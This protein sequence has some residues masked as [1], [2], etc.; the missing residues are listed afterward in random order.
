MIQNK[1]VTNNRKIIE[2]FET[3][4]SKEEIDRLL[5]KHFGIRGK[6][7]YHDDGSISVAGD[8]I[9]TDKS[10]TCLPVK[11]RKV[12]GYFHCFN[13]KLTS[14]E[15]SPQEVGVNFDC[16]STKII[17]LKGGPKKVGVN[18]NCYN[19]KIT[20][21]EGSPQEVGGYFSCESTNIISLKGSPKKVGSTFWC[22]NTKITSLEGAPEF[23]RSYFYCDNTPFFKQ[24]LVDENTQISAVKYLPKQF[25]Q[26]LNRKNIKISQTVQV[27]TVDTDPTVIK[28]IKNPT[29]MAQLTAVKKNPSVIEFIKNPDPLVLQYLAKK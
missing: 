10:I 24:F 23:V 13:S 29:R 15:G 16:D 20:S 3:T 2:L 9:L 7:E 26:L 6:I 18:F 11:F 17:S 28:W 1:R 8:V 22:N 25:I 21:L 27:V 5:K 19:T 14:L 12:D 4:Q